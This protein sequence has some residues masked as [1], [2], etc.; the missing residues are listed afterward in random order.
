MADEYAGIKSESGKKTDE[1]VE[2]RDV[3]VGALHYTLHPFLGR[4][5]GPMLGL[6]VDAGLPSFD[7]RRSTDAILYLDSCHHG[8]VVHAVSA[9][10]GSAMV[11]YSAHVVLRIVGAHLDREIPVAPED[12]ASGLGFMAGK[13]PDHVRTIRSVAVPEMTVLS[14]VAAEDELV[15]T[16]VTITYGRIQRRLNARV[17]DEPRNGM[18]HQCIGYGLLLDDGN[19]IGHLLRSF[20]RL[21]HGGIA[22][23][24]EFL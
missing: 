5:D 11:R 23:A 16:V 14:C 21:D 17:Q 12:A 18:R 9:A 22:S 7:V 10:D 19:V 6:I 13:A 2:E 8:G 24:V 20:K 1:I 4:T 15:Q 3:M